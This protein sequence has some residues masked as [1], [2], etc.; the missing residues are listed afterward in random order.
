MNIEV[1]CPKCGVLC[2]LDVEP[3]DNGWYKGDTCFACKEPL[4]PVRVVPSRFIK[5]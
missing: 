5:A 1:G 3:D 2:I 4:P